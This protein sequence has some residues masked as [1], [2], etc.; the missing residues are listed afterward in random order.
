MGGFGLMAIWALPWHRAGMDTVARLFKAASSRSMAG[1]ACLA[2]A[3]LVLAAQGCSSSSSSGGSRLGHSGGY[4]TGP[5][6]TR[7]M[8]EQGKVDLSGVA[9]VPIRYENGDGRGCNRDYNV[10]GKDYE[11]WN[12][13]DSYIE[14]GTASWYGPG[15]NGRKTSLGEIYDQ[16]GLSAAHKNLPLPS[17]LKVTNLQNG[18]KLVLRVNDRGPFSGSRI[19]DLSEGA[20][21]QL[22]VIG[23]GT[24]KVRIEYLDVGPGG[25]VRNATGSPNVIS[26]ASI[27]AVSPASSG[28]SSGSFSTVE[29]FSGKSG[30]VNSDGWISYDN[31]SVAPRARPSAPRASPAA[32]AG[33]GYNNGSPGAPAPSSAAAAPSGLSGTFVQMAATSD[34]SKAREI[35]A[36]MARR[37]NT[38]VRVAT[39][40]G[41]SRV[42]AGPFASEAKAQEALS[43]ARSMGAPDSFIRRF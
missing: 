20:A 3:A 16:K 32:S 43:S 39:A 7:P 33:A 18:R 21:R 27:P 35:C 9:S 40:G 13:M 1:I 42:L 14:E 12:G 17:Y 11:V 10:L 31:A 15:F 19:L 26:S 8:P 30:W 25:S 6:H 34:E 41:V 29:G 4:G 37:L 24:A 5:G 28:S 2:L 38:N 36:M 23:P 22:G